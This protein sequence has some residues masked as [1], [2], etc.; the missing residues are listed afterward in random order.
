MYSMI[1]S[2]QA[3]VLPASERLGVSAVPY[4][5]EIVPNV[6]TDTDYQIRVR[7]FVN[8]L[9]MANPLQYNNPRL[10]QPF[11][12]LNTVKVTLQ[13]GDIAARCAN[14][15]PEIVP[16]AGAAALG[17]GLVVDC[18]SAVHTLTVRS[19]NPST[20]LEIPESLAWGSPRIQRIS[21]DRHVVSA[22]V[23]SPPLESKTFTMTGVPNMLAIYV[24]RPRL[25][26]TDAG[27]DIPGIPS[28]IGSTQRG[29]GSIF[30]VRPSDLGLTDEIMNGSGETI[31]GIVRVTVKGAS[32]D[33]VCYLR[34]FLLYD[35]FVYEEDVRLIGWD[36][37]QYI[38]TGIDLFSKKGYA[39]ALLN[40]KADTVAEA[41]D[42]LLSEA[43]GIRSVR[44]DKGT[45]F[46]NQKFKAVLKRHNVKQILSLPGKPQ[47]NG[48]VER[49]NGILKEMI[50]KS[51][52]AKGTRDWPSYL[53]E[54]VDVY[55]NSYQITIDMTPNEAHALEDGK[56]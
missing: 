2:R 3:Q 7:F 8:D 51:M 31:D 17:K 10:A 41:M 20:A 11:K 6:A 15:N 34:V 54:L 38:L 43:H 12:D 24:E 19:W 18:I 55:N 25:L 26:K 30:Y 47:S 40:K 32:T 39:R 1:L 5:Y 50:R 27:V 21:N 33:E 49:F 52:R 23:I 29:A 45:E 9:L 22:N 42:N 13:L 53:Q 4:N 44:S 46:I 14:L 37:I 56:A 48:Q 28:G 16:A 36:G 35:V